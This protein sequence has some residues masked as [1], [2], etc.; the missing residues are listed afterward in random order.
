MSSIRAATSQVP[1]RICSNAVGSL[2]YSS[3]GRPATAF[4]AKFGMVV[5]SHTHLW[6]PMASRTSLGARS[7]KRAGS[8]PSNIV[9]GSTT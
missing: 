9:P 8:R 1:R 5:P 2:P 6:C 3:R 4:S 7:R